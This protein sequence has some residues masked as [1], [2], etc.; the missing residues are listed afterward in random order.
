VSGNVLHRLVNKGKKRNSKSD[1]T[2][3][4]WRM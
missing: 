1:D 2:G 4:K 3:C